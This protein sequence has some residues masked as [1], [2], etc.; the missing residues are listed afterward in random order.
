VSDS[1][2]ERATRTRH[3]YAQS[4]SRK[5]SPHEAQIAKYSL[6]VECLRRIVRLCAPTV[7]ETLREARGGSG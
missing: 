2:A 1:I 6:P 7:E 4:V 3:G 5:V